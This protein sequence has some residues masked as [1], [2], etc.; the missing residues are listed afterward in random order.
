MSRLCEFQ[1][2]PLLTDTDTVTFSLGE[3][4]GA[5]LTFVAAA[6]DD[7][8]ATASAARRNS[9]FPAAALLPCFPT[10]AS[11]WKKGESSSTEPTTPSRPSSQPR[12]PFQRLASPSSIFAAPPDTTTP[13]YA[14]ASSTMRKPLFVIHPTMPLCCVTDESAC[15][16][17]LGRLA[18][19]ISGGTAQAAS[20]LL[21]R[22][23]TRL[24]SP[25]SAA[26]WQPSYGRNRRAMLATVAGTAC[27][28]LLTVTLTSATAADRD[29][30]APPL[31]ALSTRRVVLPSPVDQ[32]CWSPD[33]SQLI[34][35]SHSSPHVYLWQTRGTSP[36]PLLLCSHPPTT[37]TSLISFSPDGARLLVGASSG[38]FAIF[39]ALHPWPVTQWRSFEAPLIAASWSSCG[40][41]L[42]L[43]CDGS[44]VFH[45]ISFDDYAG[46]DGRVHRSDS[47]ARHEEVV[48]GGDSV[49]YGGDIDSLSVDPTGNRLVVT[50][51]D[52]PS[53]L[54]LFSLSYEPMLAIDPVAIL[55]LPE[56][57]GSPRG[58]AWSGRCPF[59]ATLWVTG[60]SGFVWPIPLIFGTLQDRSLSSTRRSAAVSSA[61]TPA[62]ARATPSAPRFSM[63]TRDRPRKPLPPA[64]GSTPFLFSPSGLRNRSAIHQ[65]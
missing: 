46:T 53:L 15:R 34:L 26:A 52:T 24:A 4:N 17:S 39:A 63:P 27:L 33:G 28:T 25:I 23:A 31:D 56:T 14:P 18:P 42:F 3:Q 13:M 38:S 58:L 30:S 6:H 8:S 45:T 16:I 54:A 12:Q 9:A 47:V 11:G 48:E 10:T 65:Q 1:D 22:D 40:Q 21:V 32:L 57:V 55:R 7:L 60:S 41:Y 64:Q 37:S 29:P 44:S 36:S 61:A 49:G 35:A 2:P 5:G 43:A 19:P 51:R 62:T 50:F 20:P 59:G